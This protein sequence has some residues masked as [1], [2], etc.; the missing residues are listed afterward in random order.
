MV[1]GVI[2]TVVISIVAAIVSALSLRRYDQEKV[3]TSEGDISACIDQLTELEKKA[4]AGTI[5]G[6]EADV[7]RADIKRRILSAGRTEKLDMA[8]LSLSKRNL[9]VVAVAGIAIVGSFGLY[10]WNNDLANSI[11]SMQLGSRNSTSVVDQLAAATAALPPG[12]LFLQNQQRGRVQGQ[13]QATLGSVDE[14]I[15][16]VVQR[17]KRN[18]KDVEGWRVLG[19][20]YFNTDRFEESSAAYAKAIELS[21]N[22]AE[23]RS[24]YGEALVR[25]AA[26]NVTDEAKAVFERTLQLNPADSRAHFFIGLSKEQAGDKMSALND[27]I[28]ILNHG[29][30]SEPWF[31]D[32][33]QRANKLGQDVGVDVSSL[34]HRG[35][36]ETTGGVLGS[37]EKQQ[38]A[39][40]DAARKTE[41]TA[42]DVRNAEAMAPTDR[43]AMIRGMV[44]R[45][46]ARLEE[47]PNDVEGWIKLI[48]SRKI[49]GEN[50]AA[51][52]AFH[53]ALDIF[54]GAPQEQEK[55]VTV[56]H[57]LGLL[58]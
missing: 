51:E 21:P 35:N 24:A 23:L 58:Q 3:A 55:I 41:P 8:R 32:L 5:D 30:S 46:V 53:R 1:L 34:L 12:P 15:D 36:A 9:A 49:L 56:G 7:T 37:L 38:S 29:D 33:T 47:T 16:R 2:L 19:W 28:A 54:K 26:G 27:W 22:N 50:D 20:S 48:R 31:A 11:T 39:A 57:G 52:E 4:A 18:P 40:P 42:E 6:N 25:A 44:D 17:L 14:M 10:A 43:A 45:L 13:Q